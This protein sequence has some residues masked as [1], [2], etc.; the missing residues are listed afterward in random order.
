MHHRM[1]PSK[2]GWPS[3]NVVI[4]PPV[5][6]LVL[7]DPKTVTNPGIIDQ[8]HALILEDRRI[9]AKPVAENWAS[10]VSELG[11]SFMKIWTCRSPPRRGSRNAWT[12]VKNV[13]GAGRLTDFGIFSARSKWFPVA[14]GDH[15][16]NLLISLWPGDKA[17]ISGGA[18]WRLTPPQEIP[19]AEI[20][21]KSSRLDFLGWRRHPPHWLSSKGPNY[22]LGVLLIS[23][24]AIELH[25]EGRTRREA[26]QNGLLLARQCPGSPGTWNPEKTGLPGL[27][28][29]D[30]PPSSPDQA[31]WD[32]HLFPGLKKS[33][34]MDAIFRPT[35]RSLLPRRPG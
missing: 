2:T 25:F 34:W 20:R 28:C 9:S 10:H 18:A 31:P 27:P 8:I 13:N 12:R 6:R 23:A 1:P 30:H 4:F 17:T 29:L 11:P 19:S 3:L 14:I 7:D 22:Q 32:Y 26:H 5:L 35:R 33:N 24:G 16:R 15:G 21:R